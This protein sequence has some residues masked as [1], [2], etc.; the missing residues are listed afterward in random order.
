MCLQ[1]W[2][3]TLFYYTSASRQEILLLLRTLSEALVDVNSEQTII[4]ELAL[5]RR[6]LFVEE[7]LSTLFQ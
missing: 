2:S 3:C 4:D 1:Y 7:L 6:L 5:R